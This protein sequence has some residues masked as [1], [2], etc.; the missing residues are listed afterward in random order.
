MWYGRKNWKHRNQHG[1]SMT[2]Q[3]SPVSKTRSTLK[4]SID[5]ETEGN[6]N[7]DSG[8]GS[9][10]CSTSNSDHLKRATVLSFTELMTNQITGVSWTLQT[11]LASIRS[12][13]QLLFLPVWC[14]RA[15]WFV[16]I[17]F[18][19]KMI[20]LMVLNREALLQPRAHVI[21]QQSSTLSN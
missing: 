5:V 10:V 13:E 15:E 6:P 7:S 12:R 4:T 11:C 18:V 14:R 17:C 1:A 2:V 20:F 9:I 3:S 16:C 21:L 8:C 19:C